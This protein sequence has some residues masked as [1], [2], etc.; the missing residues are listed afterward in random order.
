MVCFLLFP[1]LVLM[2]GM[3]ATVWK[4]AANICRRALH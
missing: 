1:T 4:S 2:N 3:I